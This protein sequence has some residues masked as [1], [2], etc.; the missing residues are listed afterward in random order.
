MLDL[1]FRESINERIRVTANSE[2]VT[3]ILGIELL[4]FTSIGLISNQPTIE[5]SSK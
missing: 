4:K 2:V 5:I 1:I 3:K